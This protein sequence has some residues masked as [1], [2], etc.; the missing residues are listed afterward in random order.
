MSGVTPQAIKELRERTSAGM[1]DCKNALVETGGDLEKAVEVILKK[2]LAKSA[3]RASAVA[4][5][6]EVRA[7]VSADKREATII[8]VNI[9]TD[10]AARSEGFQ[11]FVAEVMKAA[12]AAPAGSDIQKAPL[13]GK[14]VGEVSAELTG[15]IGEKVDVRRW[16]RLSVPAGKQGLAVSYVHLGGKIGV[17][18]A[19]E[20]ESAAAAAHEE[21]VKFADE[22]AMQIAAMS[23]IVLK[24]DEVTADTIGKQKEIFEGQL[25][26]DPKPKPEASWPKIIEGKLNKWFSEAALV[27]QE[28][29]VTPGKTIEQLRE[30]ASKAAGA[31]VNIVRFVRYERGD[32]LTKKE[33]NFAE[34][35]AKMAG[36]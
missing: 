23:P 16:D 10:F 13:S 26:E 31:Q 6:G 25:K 18:L 9:Q 30:A 12:S 35:V 28:S 4:T 27:E 22:T 24:R 21:V 7:T 3:K 15:K 1:S 2:G 8:E 32:G 36:G 11:S 17:L 34:E 33:D 5:E 20:T 19:L 14:T 29:V